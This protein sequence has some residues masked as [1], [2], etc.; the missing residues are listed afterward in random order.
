[1]IE[2]YAVGAASGFALWLGG[3]LVGA[4]RAI[5]SRAALRS[6]LSRAQADEAR[7]RAHADDLAERLPD[8]AAQ[9][10]QLEA[11][12]GRLRAQH[13]AGSEIESARLRAELRGMRAALDERA[14]A[15]LV[16]DR[17]ASTL[18]EALHGRAG[19]LEAGALRAGLEAVL[20]ATV[21]TAGLRRAVISD[22]NGLVLATSDGAQGAAEVGA[23]W[24]H[25]D[26]LSSQLDGAGQGA[27]ASA[28]LVDE[29][30]RHYRSRW[31]DLP[32]WQCLLTVEGPE[33]LPPAA[34]DPVVFALG[35]VFQAS[36]DRPFPPL[37][38]PAAQ[39]A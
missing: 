39:A 38:R 30:G 8:V 20:N 27:L 16:R 14:A 11:L 22:A 15:Q 6:A 17:L 26:R 5:A 25:L 7:A 28:S 1:M 36:L 37:P 19:A 9:A 33:S 24:V 4:R 32:G 10:A 31:V 18:H 35:R 2:L 23:A 3:Y 21:V 13:E 34:L 12:A 29:R